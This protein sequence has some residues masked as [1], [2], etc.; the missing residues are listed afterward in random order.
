MPANEIKPH[1]GYA[2]YG[3]TGIFFLFVVTNCLIFYFSPSD[4]F[5]ASD[6]YGISVAEMLMKHGRF[7]QGTQPDVPYTSWPPGRGIFLLPFLA[8]AG[9]YADEL[10]RAVQVGMLF[11][12]GLIL[13]N[14][15]EM[16]LPKGGLI[17]MSLLIFNPL[18]LGYAHISSTDLLHGFFITASF[19]FLFSWVNSNRLQA[20][21]YC[22][23]T[24]ALATL[25]RPTSQY[26]VLLLPLIFVLLCS[27]HHFGI[28]IRLP[29]SAG[30][31][32]TISAL[33]I[34]APW[35][36]HMNTAGEGLKISSRSIETLTVVENLAQYRE[37]EKHGIFNLKDQTH[38]LEKQKIHKEISELIASAYP[39]FTSL[40]QLEK[41]IIERRQTIEYLLESDLSLSVGFELALVS[42]M[43]TVLSGGI[44]VWFK[45]LG[46][47]FKDAPMLFANLK[48]L[49]LGYSIILKVLCIFGLVWL[50]RRGKYALVLL[51]SGLI[52]YYVLLPLGVGRPRFRVAVEMPMAVLAIFGI[53][54]I[55]RLFSKKPDS[56]GAPE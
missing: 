7:V 32:S 53:C 43:R 2:G 10:A 37:V 19:Y 20:S 1:I 38:K 55:T 44:G 17:A 31:L 24:L 35:A 16:H 13:K 51:V 28:R 22:G 45:V 29:L 49:T 15:I 46:K 5:F 50:L 4:S 11:S 40:S 42:S 48:F 8:L 33:A 30:L 27:I 36:L 12:M 23:F 41:G 47:N 21:V 56:F 26:L 25:V 34:L 6:R 39:S 52:L 14:T 9:H 3:L 18:M 54:Q